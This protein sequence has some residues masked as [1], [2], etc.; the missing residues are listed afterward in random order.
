MF[1]NAIWYT[2]VL[3]TIAVCGAT[4][5]S[6]VGPFLEPAA[7]FLDAAGPLPSS[8]AVRGNPAPR[9]SQGNSG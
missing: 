8:A 6:Y 5:L 1:R 4:L 3:R 7:A 9:V 2:A